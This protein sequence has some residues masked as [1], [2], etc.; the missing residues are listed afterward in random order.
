VREEHRTKIRAS[1]HEVVA[2]AARF[3]VVAGAPHIQTLERPDEVAGA[4]GAFLPAEI[5]IP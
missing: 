2:A 4:L 5:D 3:E 1:D